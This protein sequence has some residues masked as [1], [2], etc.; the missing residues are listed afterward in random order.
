[1]R[2]V[3]RHRAPPAGVCEGVLARAGV[4]QLL[5][6]SRAEPLHLVGDKLRREPSSPHLV[7]HRETVSAQGWPMTVPHL[8]ERV[9]GENRVLAVDVLL[10]HEGETGG[11]HV[12]Q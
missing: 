11:Y 9:V 12:E 1:M 10:I 3:Q 6:Q 5:G 2:V 4:L 7:A 8:V